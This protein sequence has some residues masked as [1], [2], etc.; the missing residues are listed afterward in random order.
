M[1]A[2]KPKGFDEL[3]SLCRMEISIGQ[4]YHEGEKLR[5]ALDWAR[6]NYKQTIILLGD[7]Q[8]RF[9]IAFREGLEI[10]QALK[11]A[12]DRGI[13]WVDRNKS[14]IGDIEVISWNYFLNHPN[15]LNTKQAVLDLLDNGSEFQVNLEDAVLDFY[16]RSGVSSSQRDEFMSIS[17]EY[18]IEE[19]AG[20]AIAY[21][22][23]QGFSAYPGSFFDMW[24][25][26]IG[27]KTPKG[28]EGLSNAHCVRLC[29]NRRKAA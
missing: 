25:C 4:P 18:L 20:L 8:Q 23:Y 26:F 15:F 29:F 3:P 27:K 19:T 14:I 11:V 13:E 17:R 12:Y 28:L 9:N 5:L 1:R 2:R 10:N 16:E 21:K 24:G 6:N 22:E 7:T